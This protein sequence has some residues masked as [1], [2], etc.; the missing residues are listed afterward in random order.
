MELA[1]EPLNKIALTD[2]AGVPVIKDGLM[3]DEIGEQKLSRGGI[4]ADQ[5]CLR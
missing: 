1:T 3:G 5:R 2:A 4:R